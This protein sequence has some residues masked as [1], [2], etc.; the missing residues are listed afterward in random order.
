M[1][2]NSTNSALQPLA[3]ILRDVLSIAALPVTFG[4]IKSI[5]LLVGTA[6]FE[7]FTRLDDQQ[8]QG[9]LDQLVAVGDAVAAGDGRY[10]ATRT[11]WDAVRPLAA[12][13]AYANLPQ[14][15][16][17]AMPVIGVYGDIYAENLQRDIKNAFWWADNALLQ[18]SL[19]ILGNHYREETESEP[20]FEFL[21]EMPQE[22]LLAQPERPFYICVQRM[23]PMYARDLM[24]G[25]PLLSQAFKMAEN[26]GNKAICSMV[27]YAILINDWQKVQPLLN[28]LPAG[29]AARVTRV[30]WCRFIQGQDD[31]AASLYL[32]ALTNLRRDERD[33]NTFF[34]TIGG[35]FMPM[36][37][38]RLNEEN[39]LAMALSHT[40]CAK[41][42]PTDFTQVYAVLDAVARNRSNV[43]LPPDRAVWSAS[44]PLS[45]LFCCIAQFW[46]TGQLS[47]A[48]RLL[49]DRASSRAHEN[50]YT[51]LAEECDELCSRLTDTTPSGAH[52]WHD[53]KNSRMP[54]MLDCVMNQNSWVE[55]M[56][57]IEQS[58][59]Q[60]PA[61]DRR[62]LSWA[63]NIENGEQP[64]ITVKPI[65]QHYTRDHWSKGRKYTA[66]RTQSWGEIGPGAQDT[67]HGFELSAQDK[68]ACFML[69]Q[70]E[71]FCAAHPEG[72][73]QAWAQ[74][75]LCL[76]DHPRLFLDGAESHPIKC[77]SA[78]PRVVVSRVGENYRYGLYPKS[79]PGDGAV[80]IMENADRL[81]V[82]EF[83]A[84]TRQLRELFGDDFQ[85]P[86]ES[87]QENID[88]INRL[89][90][91][92]Q[93]IA[94]TELPL[95]EPH[96][97][98]AD[99]T[100]CVRL[101]PSTRGLRVEVLVCPFGATGSYYHPGE[102]P[103]EI[104]LQSGNGLQRLTRN[105]P[106][107]LDNANGIVEKCPLLVSVVPAEPWGWLLNA[108]AAYEFSLQLRQISSLC[109]I[110]WPEDQK[111]VCR[112][113]LT[114]SNVSLRTNSYQ[115]W[116]GVS[117]EV[118]LEDSDATIS[119]Q[120]LIQSAIVEH[121]RFIALNDG[122]IVALSD[123]LRKNLED[124]HRLGDLVGGERGHLRISPFLMSF[125]GDAL[126]RFGDSQLN[127]GCEEWLRT[128]NAA[129][130]APHQI[131][132]TL[133]ASLRAYQEEGF[134]WVARLDQIHAGACL[135]DD[136]GLGKTVQAI[137]MILSCIDEG[138]GL[139]VAPTSVCPNWQA[140]LARFAPSLE[141]EIFGPG[142]RAMAFKRMKAGR[143]MITSYGLLQ[144]EQNAFR[145]MHWRI[146]VLDEAQA[147]KNSHAKR[148]RAAL[149]INADFRL[150]TT[151]TPVENNLNELWSIFNFIIPGLLGSR[152]SFQHKYAAPI[153][154]DSDEASR[155]NVAGQLRTLI[156]PFLL[157]RRKEQVLTELPPKEDIDYYIDLS[158][159]ERAFYDNLRR[160]IAAD[161]EREGDSEIQRNERVLCGITMLREAVDHPSMVEGAGGEGLPS[162]KLEAFLEL[163]KGVLSN[164]HKVLVF[165]QFTKF[166]DIVCRSLDD[167]GIKYGYLDGSMSQS[168][169]RR[170][171]EEFQNGDVPVFVSSLK[172][173]CLGLNLTQ[174]DYVIH[175]DSWWNPAVENQASDRAYRLGQKRPVTIYHL[176]VRDTIDEKIRQ[177]HGHKQNLADQ[178][179]ENS[180]DLST[181][182]S[183]E[184]IRRILCED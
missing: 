57:R 170:A 184:E 41:Q 147:I 135:A 40:E 18:Q 34:R 154:T 102:G 91:R 139:I 47:P 65:E 103:V 149:S 39:S 131:P 60:M 53:A 104:L 101:V 51:W 116:F 62:R 143:V 43:G 177:L 27:D 156:S 84:A 81:C 36:T 74:V 32:D 183:M 6:Q 162:S 112:R 63:V 79:M 169:R 80:A 108:N 182:A 3:G 9:L 10:R 67:I 165:S 50:G 5:L 160:S 20:F 180:D 77:C 151:G 46:L 8:L 97:A 110:Q 127:E 159:A 54:F 90:K 124:L 141:C 38:L 45:D 136:M 71:E 19:S 172:A 125:A 128:Y 92:C 37:E 85:V 153:E 181:K 64:L 48:Q 173:G 21:F 76:A 25:R 168:E 33:H 73:R 115:D 95:A 175:L 106:Q 29:S 24:D 117:G 94:E 86:A 68:F 120:E 55:R 148:S 121:K 12:N 93:I 161:L 22:W 134:L 7:E 99:A 122:Q 145:N 113:T 163:L 126:G 179:L 49:L 59:A 130:Q 133:N 174:A 158:D 30:A 157:R 83:D 164:D 4:E 132:A 16:S 98:P 56:T 119:L 142:D 176:R 87:G 155:K 15:I 129:M 146:A 167:N 66:Y 152:D 35:L 14:V 2:P 82:Y 13:P 123:T 100:P 178:M 140:E 58:L 23:L 144:S 69:R 107:E 26:A 150:V 11:G 61:C 52:R 75:L 70:C 171:V 88:I 89:A 137:S 31:V 111:Y 138:P 96:S 42:I 118:R 72:R 166:L 28:R 105:L 1:A 114:L 109:R 78:T 17:R 44:S